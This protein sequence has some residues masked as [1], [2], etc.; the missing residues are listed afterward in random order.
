MLQ[1]IFKYLIFWYAH[2]FLLL[3]NYSISSYFI[4]LEAYKIEYAIFSDVRKM[5][6]MTIKCNK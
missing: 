2:I 1:V 3:L 6:S 4:Q 5:Y